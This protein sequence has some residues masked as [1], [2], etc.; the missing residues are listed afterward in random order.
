MNEIAQ[1]GFLH[2][3]RCLDKISRG[4]SRAGALARLDL[5]WVVEPF[6]FKI[7]QRSGRMV[8]GD[9]VRWVSILNEADSVHR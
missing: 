2:E 5:G 1:A 9:H 3:F 8:N 7:L 4:R 6:L